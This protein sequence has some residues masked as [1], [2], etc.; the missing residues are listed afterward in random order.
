MSAAGAAGGR[1]RRPDMRIATV[2][3]ESA[4]QEQTSTFL[5]SPTGAITPL[6]GGQAFANDDAGSDGGFAYVDDDDGDDGFVIEVSD[7]CDSAS[8]EVPKESTHDAVMTPGT[9]ATEHA[10]VLQQVV[11]VLGLPEMLA[12]ALLAHFKFD[13]AKLMEQYVDKPE[14]T[15]AAIG[16][17]EAPPAPGP[18]AVPA[19]PAGSGG[20]ELCE[21]C[22]A[23]NVAR[24]DTTA[25]PCGHRYCNV[26]WT[27]YL[28]SKIVEGVTSVNCMWDGP[29]GC[30]QAVPEAVVRRLCDEATFE[31]FQR[32]MLADFVQSSQFVAWCPAPGCTN[33]V[34]FESSSE[35]T[36][37]CG[38]RFCVD[39]SKECHVPLSCANMREWEKKMSDEGQVMTWLQHHTKEC[40][41]CLK[42][43]E[44]NGGCN[45]MTCRSNAGGC[46]HEF[47]WICGA[48]WR[49]HSCNT[50]YDPSGNPIL[51]NGW[52]TAKRSDKQDAAKLLFYG[53]RFTAHL[54]SKK[55]ESALRTT[56]PALIARYR[57]KHPE[58]SH[59][60]WDYL[61]DAADTLVYCRQTLAY[62]YAASFFIESGS[63]E[64]NL[65]E[66]LQ[67]EL[68]QK[69]E[70]L[71]HQ[72]EMP[73]RKQDLR[74]VKDLTRNALRRLRH[75]IEGHDEGLVADA[76]DRKLPG[77]GGKR[78]WWQFGK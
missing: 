15:L 57:A 20:L 37:S 60:D 45:H 47:C 77:A 2:S 14:A 34:R 46:G 36:C 22:L 19:T 58:R 32:F 27:S 33:A 16:W 56:I 35:A 75:L 24:L 70:A 63:A 48:D 66:F 40:P 61:V 54:D 50:Q 38:H 52:P 42:P 55:L 10:E 78:R 49:G 8:A 31:K 74:R 62:T 53:N 3:W 43:I 72:L 4:G 59:L 73:L 65:F 30:K 12:R 71:S 11:E 21:V 67:K 26:C 68:E 64:R 23:E 13:K 1:F 41:R 6:A 25:L 28:A 7:S 69:T 17:T 18:G 29:G 44:K 5:V 51:P 9:L 76:D 39:C